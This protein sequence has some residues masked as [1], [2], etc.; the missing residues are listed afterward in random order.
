M[1]ARVPALLGTAVLLCSLASGQVQANEG[2][3]VEVVKPERSLVRDELVTFS[4]LRPDESVDD[5]SGNCRASGATA[6]S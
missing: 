4:S 3:L 1:F 5:P 6:F 2:P